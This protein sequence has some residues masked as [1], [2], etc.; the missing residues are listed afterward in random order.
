MNREIKCEGV[1]EIQCIPKKNKFYWLGTN[2]NDPL[3]I[4]IPQEN[5]PAQKKKCI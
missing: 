5:I 2:F 1:L 3:P 4:H